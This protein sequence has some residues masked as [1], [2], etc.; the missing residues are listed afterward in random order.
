MIR[1]RTLFFLFFLILGMQNANSQT[2]K[3]MTTGFSVME[4]DAKGN[5]GKWSELEKVSLL[6]TLD[7]DK[8]RIVVYSREIQVYEI[9]EYVEKKENKDEEIYTFICSDLDGRPF[10]ISIITRKNQDNR[11]QL[12]INEKNVILVYNI[13]NHVDKNQK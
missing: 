13:K 6:V 12:Y 9:V 4:K 7:T 10:T 5:W 11:K 3:F 1:L 8:N 2:Y